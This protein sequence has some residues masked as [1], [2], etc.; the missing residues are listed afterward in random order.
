MA[1]MMGT[2]MKTPEPITV[3]TMIDEV[4]TKESW[5]SGSGPGI[6]SP[7]KVPQTA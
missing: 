1:A 3:P 5:R 2:L 6:K 7:Q 4:W